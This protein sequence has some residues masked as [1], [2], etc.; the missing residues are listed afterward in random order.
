MLVSLG[1]CDLAMSKAELTEFSS[2]GVDALGPSFIKSIIYVVPTELAVAKLKL[3]T[4]QPS[5][6]S[7]AILCDDLLRGASLFGDVIGQ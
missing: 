2:P 7:D 4:A 6:L 1:N 5:V 3:Q